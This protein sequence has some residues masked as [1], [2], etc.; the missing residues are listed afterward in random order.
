MYVCLCKGLR[1]SDVE[2]MGQ[3]GITD[4]GTLTL[5]LGL[6]D[7]GCCGRCAANVRDLVDIALRGCPLSRSV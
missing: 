6:D 3:L 1:E 2:R 7:D 5:A 4:A